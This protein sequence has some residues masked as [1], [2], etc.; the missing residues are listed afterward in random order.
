MS[1]QRELKKDEKRRWY[2]I[3]AIIFIAIGIVALTLDGFGIFPHQWLANNWSRRA[4]VPSAATL[5]VVIGII[6]WIISSRHAFQGNWIISPSMRQVIVPIGIASVLIGISIAILSSLGVLQGSWTGLLSNIFNYSGWLMT[7]LSLPSSTNE[8]HSFSPQSQSSNAT[9]HEDYLHLHPF[10]PIPASMQF[11]NIQG[12]PP[13]YDTKVIQPYQ[14]YVE[15]VYATL[16]KSSAPITAVALTGYSDA[17]T[18]MLAASIYHESKRQREAYDSP[19]EADELW[20]SIDH[21]VTL[22]DII[23]TLYQSQHIPPPDFASMTIRNQAAAFIEALNTPG[24]ARLVVLDRFENWQDKPKKNSHGVEECLDALN[25]QAC[26]SRVLITCHSLYRRGSKYP[27]VYLLENPLQKAT[28][29]EGRLTNS[30]NLI[31]EIFTKELNHT[32]RVLLCVFSIYREKIPLTKAHLGA[33]LSTDTEKLEMQSTINKLVELHL[34]EY[35]GKDDYIISLSAVPCAQRHFM[36]ITDEA[37]RQ[38]A[39]RKAH[40]NAARYYQQEAETMKRRGDPLTQKTL[41]EAVWH[42]CQANKM[43]K[44]YN[45]VQSEALLTT[46]PTSANAQLFLELCRLLQPS[47]TWN[48]DYKKAA[49]IYNCQERTY[50]VLEKASSTI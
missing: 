34:L 49:I 41:I 8:I 32:Q 2:L 14:E 24:K 19:F 36:E 48:P 23:G 13:P 37:A 6:M 9:K 35:C 10:Q 33:G 16:T 27:P 18:S 40:S 31:E 38:K 25:S 22:I 47:D 46:V 3:L 5:L 12:V 29:T 26:R 43:D 1:A 28:S 11:R 7:L 20:L 50:N 45:L 30:H 15:E 17:T 39:L 42:L 4:F 44:A 21:D